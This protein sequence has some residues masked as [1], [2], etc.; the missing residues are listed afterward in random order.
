ASNDTEEGRALNR[1]VEV[2]VWY[3]EIKDAV[4]EQEVLVSSDVRKIKVC[5][6]ETVC[7]LRYKEGAERRARVK[8]LV[9][10]LRYDDETTPISD[11]FTRQVR[12]ALDNLKDRQGVTVRFIGYTDDAPL[13]DR[14]KRIYG[15]A[16]AL[17]K[18]R[19]RRVALAMKDLLK[20]PT[21]A[22][23]SDGPGAGPAPRARHRERPAGGAAGPGREPAPR[24]QRHRR[25][26]E[27]APAVRRLHEE[28]APRPPHRRGVRR[29]RRAVRRPR[30]PRAGAAPA[31]SG[32][33]G[34]AGR[35]RGPR[36]RPV[37]RCRQ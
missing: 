23:E 32:A 28:R 13:S 24:P 11:D 34:R 4:E 31:G 26:E 6:T 1:R 3:D 17:S 12:Q 30:A 16:V 9:T 35:A 18:A 21:S 25:P 33:G 36:L 27:P 2:E 8:N 29:R 37:R 5:R 10:P 20:L 19:A 15:D 7:M 22:L 14:D